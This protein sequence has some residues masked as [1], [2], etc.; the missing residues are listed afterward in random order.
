MRNKLIL[1]SNSPRRQQLMQEVGFDFEVKTMEVAEDYGEMPAEEV[2]EYLAIKK[3]DAYRKV[4]KDEIVVTAD[5]IVVNA[6][7]VLG[8]PASEQEAVEMIRA[9]SGGSHAVISAVCISDDQRKVSFS[10]DVAVKMVALSDEEIQFY[11]KKYQP[12][13]KA[14]AYGIQEWIGMVGIEQ[15]SGS[16][17][18]VMGLPIH[19]VYQSLKS[20]FGITPML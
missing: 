6:G 11:V 10:D 3:N 16:F 17:Y 7:I 20:D 15:I 12:M 5:T 4:L 8:K 13:D 18:S 2:A 19:K 9:M 1:A 14:G